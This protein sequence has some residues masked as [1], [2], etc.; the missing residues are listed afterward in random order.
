MQGELIY[1]TNVETIRA[2]RTIASGVLQTRDLGTGHQLVRATFP[3][4]EDWIP[5]CAEIVLAHVRSGRFTMVRDIGAGLT[6]T[7]WRPGL[8]LLTPDHATGISRWPGSPPISTLEIGLP[9]PALSRAAQVL[10]GEDE[11]DLEALCRAP[12][13]D[14]LISRAL[15]SLWASD[16]AVALPRLLAEQCVELILLQLVRRAFEHRSPA[17][18]SG[19]TALAPWALKR[20]IGLIEA[21]QGRTSVSPN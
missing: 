6:E 14:T 1:A 18:R 20:L 4:G 17:P 11:I 10:Y 8:I 19:R 2:T 3:A 21:R 16:E 13:E 15:L 9:A 7:Q 5:G 12:L